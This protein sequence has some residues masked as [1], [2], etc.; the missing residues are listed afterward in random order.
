M[1]GVVPTLWR[2]ILFGWNKATEKSLY[3]NKNSREMLISTTYVIK[4][5]VKFGWLAFV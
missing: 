4:Y 1:M 3:G 2:V 5:D